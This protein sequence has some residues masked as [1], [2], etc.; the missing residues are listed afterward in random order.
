MRLSL[1]FLLLAGFSMAEEAKVRTLSYRLD[2]LAMEGVLVMPAGAK[3]D[4]PGLVLFPDWMGV[5][6]VAVG[7]AKRVA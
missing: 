2:T 1:L 4:I 5:G 6:P 3:G 7:Y